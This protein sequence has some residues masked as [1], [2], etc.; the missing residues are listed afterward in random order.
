MNV[1]WIYKELKM[2][3]L[4]RF[5]ITGSWHEHKWIEVKHVKTINS[6]GDYYKDEYLCRCEKCGTM[7]SFKL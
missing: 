3:R 6:D 4:L 2:L 5:L 1:Q 7:K